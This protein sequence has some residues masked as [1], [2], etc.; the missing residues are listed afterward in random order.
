MPKVE[1]KS[2][3]TYYCCRCGGQYK[4]PTQF[5]KSHSNLFADNG[6]MPV[7]KK[8][9]TELF[10]DYI[11]KYNDVEKALQR[12]C[13][14]FD[15]YYS[16]S[17]FDSCN[18]GGNSL[19]GVYIKNLNMI[20]YKDKTFDT[21]I[22]EGFVFDPNNTGEDDVVETNKEPEEFN[23][24]KKDLKKWGDGFEDVDYQVLNAHYEQ[25]KAANPNCDNNQEL[26]INDLCY[27]H[28]QKMKSLRGGDI[29]SYNKLT[30]SYRKSFK[31]AGLKTEEEALN[32]ADACWGVMLKE[33]SQYTVEEYYK[34]KTLYKDMDGLDEYYQRN[35]A[36]P[37]FNTK[38]GTQERDTEYF[39]HEEDDDDGD[40]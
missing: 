29:D 28:M 27:I 6:I 26:F 1:N 24:S 40:S 36:R 7:C 17:L 18:N 33:I 19:L 25:L 5:F 15:L 2:A 13:M 14:A 31:Q 8:C 34:D 21:S 32:N 35:C 38:F 37:L 22:K 23:V 12:I 20:Q 39:V 16:K 4:T 10:N 11:K 30:E 3:V 9:L